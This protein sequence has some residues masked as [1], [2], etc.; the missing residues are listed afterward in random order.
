MGWQELWR[1]SCDECNAPGPTDR[2]SQQARAKA[3][4][5]GWREGTAHGCVDVHLCAACAARGL[6]DWWPAEREDS[7]R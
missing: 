3:V 1:V 7:T 2:S 4:K 5:A 6:P